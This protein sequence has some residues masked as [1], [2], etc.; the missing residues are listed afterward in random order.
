MEIGRIA[1]LGLIDIY[2]YVCTESNGKAILLVTDLITKVL[3]EHR[4]GDINDEQFYEAY[5]EI[6]EYVK[7]GTSIDT[8]LEIRSF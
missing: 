8:T 2:T 3:N 5:L 1:K 6:Y 7:S 4:R